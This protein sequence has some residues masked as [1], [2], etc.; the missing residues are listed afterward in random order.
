MIREF[1]GG[2]LMQ[3]SSGILCEDQASSR[4]YSCK[5]SHVLCKVKAVTNVKKRIINYFLFLLK[6]L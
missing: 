5:T 4:L 6:R 1:L 2:H 3:N